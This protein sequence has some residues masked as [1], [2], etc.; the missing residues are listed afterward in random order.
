MNEKLEKDFPIITVGS[1]KEFLD[2]NNIPDDAIITT[3]NLSEIILDQSYFQNVFF[4]NP[5]LRGPILTTKD[6][7]ELI[8][9]NY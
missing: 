4:S 3:Q 2:K 6:G 5:R 1:L 8:V 9:N 7:K